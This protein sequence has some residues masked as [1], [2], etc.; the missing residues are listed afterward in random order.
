MNTAGAGRDL[1]LVGGG[2]S[3]LL[4][5]RALAMRGL[6]GVRISLIS[7]SSHSPYSGMLPGLIA[8]HYSF[9]ETHIDF[10]RFCTRLGVRFI[11]AE[12]A[13]VEPGER[14]V[15]LRNR[16]AIGYDLLSINTGSRPELASVDGAAEFATPVKPISDLYRRWS[17]LEKRIDGHGQNRALRIVVVGG[18]AGSIELALAMRHRL[19]GFK[20]TTLLICGQAL[21]EGY[22]RGAV[23]AVR[24]AL[25]ESAVDVIEH[26]RVVKVEAKQVLAESGEHYPY[27][28]LI[29][30]TSASAAGWLGNSGLPC[31]D[32]GFLQIEDSLQVQGHPEIFA[33][34]DA[35][36]QIRHP[37][38][39][40]GV[41]AVRQAPVLAANLR[42]FLEGGSL[43]PHRPQSR[44]LSLLSL[45]ERKAVADRG[46]LWSS[47]AWVWRWKD[48]IDRKFMSRFTDL[49]ARMPSALED[50][51][52]PMQCGGCGAKL[53][54]TM[55]RRVLS[56]S[57]AQFPDVTASSEFA[58]DAALL[59]WN[60]GLALVQS[61]DTLRQLIDDPWLMGR[62]AVL[63]A[64]SDIHAMGA[65]P[66]SA[67]AHITLPWASP[68]LQERDLEQLMH[69][70][71]YELERSGCR[72]LG[73]HSLE[74]PELSVGFTV[75]GE[76]DRRTVLGKVG[77]RP[78]DQ[79]LLTKPLGTGVLFAALAQG[80]AD[81]RWISTAVNFMLQSNGAAAD[82]A[83]RMGASACTDITGFG[84]L[85]HLLEMLQG[86]ALGALVQTDKLPV[87]PG[88]REMFEQGFESSLHG[89]NLEAVFGELDA[90]AKVEGLLCKALFDPQTSG[91]LLVSVAS[92]EAPAMLQ[93]L[94]EAGYS[95]A[96]LVGTVE[97]RSEPTGKLRLLV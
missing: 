83:C 43:Q 1:V 6:A 47:G 41:Y 62:I 26:T 16:P 42:A 39:K 93:A 23:G 9:E 55:L 3:H 36:T 37:R 77:A 81:G 48:K 84:L 50:G 85:G 46:P 8:G 30:C 34:G 91:G 78:G 31:D 38:P 11:E 20:M 60:S 4:V 69:G 19:S 90:D 25:R 22:N 2:H 82:I 86:Q 76:V 74:G 67:L 87:L 21:L 5:L 65:Q 28:E 94:R 59:D 49:P 56:R 14:C 10:S 44:F 70:A 58:D 61:V 73:G 96:A 63:H 88:A 32:E 15:S 12:V 92:G 68:R 45:G 27:D 35:A 13:G 52:V 54:A 80:A 51:D 29:W 95:Q 97:T 75:N 72:L 79:L 18:G 64:V 7:E 57:S 40:A 17:E 71:L 89:A 66:H 53:P 33:A 24:R